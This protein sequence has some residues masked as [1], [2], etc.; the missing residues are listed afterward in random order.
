[1]SNPNGAVWLAD[2]LW[3]LR[4]GETLGGCEARFESPYPLERVR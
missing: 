3:Q 1:M 4:A 2:E